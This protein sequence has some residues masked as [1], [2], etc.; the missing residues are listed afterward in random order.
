[1]TSKTT[2][3]VIHG[4]RVVTTEVRTARGVVMINEGLVEAMEQ[5]YRNL[6]AHEAL[7]RINQKYHEILRE[8]QDLVSHFVS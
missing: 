6:S 5:P 8:N 1:M 7:E 3:Q 2:R 4:V